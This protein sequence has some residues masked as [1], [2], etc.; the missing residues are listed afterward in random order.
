MRLVA[1]RPTGF[2]DNVLFWAPGIKAAR[3]VRSSTGE[4]RIPFVHSRTSQRLRSPCSCNRKRDDATITLTGPV[5][6]SYA[7]MTAKLSTALGVPIAYEMITDDAVRRAHSAFEPDP[8]MVEA[9]VGN[10][11]RAA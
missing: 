6:L 11:S 3:V 7:E 1:L 8:A 5:A 2:M 10:L 9:H 4:G